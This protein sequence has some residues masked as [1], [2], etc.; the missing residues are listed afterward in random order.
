MTFC[1]HEKKEGYNNLKKI[2][3]LI[4]VEEV[5]HKV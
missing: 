1:A 5:F 2:F 4:G 3:T